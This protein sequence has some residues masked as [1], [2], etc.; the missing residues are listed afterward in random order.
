M[1]ILKLFIQLVLILIS[2][3]V[4]KYFL[5]E[6]Q[7]IKKTY[8]FEVKPSRNMKYQDEIYGLK[9]GI[10]ANIMIVI[11]YTILIWFAL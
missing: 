5:S 2:W 8:Y 7:K 1:F 3:L 11:I 9:L 6:I 10:I 4:V